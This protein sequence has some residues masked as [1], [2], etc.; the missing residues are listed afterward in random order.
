MSEANVGSMAVESEPSGQYSVVLL[1]QRGSLTT[2][3]LTWKCG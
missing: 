1:Q 2:R 3:H